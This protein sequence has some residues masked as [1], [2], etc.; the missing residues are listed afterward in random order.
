M[1]FSGFRVFFQFEPDQP[2][3]PGRNGKKIFWVSGL[4]SKQP[5]CTP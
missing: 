4:F 1:F 5:T 2:G 3:V